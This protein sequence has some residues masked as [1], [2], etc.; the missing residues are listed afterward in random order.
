M[1]FQALL[2]VPLGLAAVLLFTFLKTSLLYQ[3]NIR[4][5][6]RERE[7]PTLPHIV[8]YLG[9]AVGFLTPVPGQ[10]FSRILS[11]FNK[12]HGGASIKLAGRNVRLIFSTVAVQAMLKVKPSVASSDTMIKDMICKGCKMSFEDWEKYTGAP[13]YGR[14]MEH[15]VSS[16]YLL[17]PAGADVLLRRFA[18]V[19]KNNMVNEAERMSSSPSESKKGE[20]ID[21]YRWLRGFMFN[22]SVRSFF[23]ERLFIE[24]PEVVKDFW[25]FEPSF[26]DLLFGVPRFVKPEPYIV[27]EKM[28]NG[29]T[30]WIEAVDR[31]M[32][33]KEPNPNSPDEDWEPLWGSR[34]IR[35]R[36]ALWRQL[37]MSAGGRASMELS[38]LFALNAN[39]LPSTGWMLMHILDP[40]RPDLFPRV[41]EEIQEAVDVAKANDNSE[42]DFDV[43]TLLTQPLLQSMFQEVLRLYVDVLITRGVHEDMKLPT[44]DRQNTLLIKK[45]SIIMAPSYVNHHDPTGFTGAPV[46]EYDPER[47][48]VPAGAV[49]SANDDGEENLFKEKESAH[50][51]ARSNKAY[52]FS[53]GRAGA[54]MI[55]FGGGRT[56]CP[57][58]VF[59]KREVFCSLALVLLN[60]DIVPVGGPTL[61]RSRATLR[62]T[63]VRGSLGTGEMS[64]FTSRREPVISDL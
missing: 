47:F 26:L 5:K 35:A 61:T 3:I 36:E 21:L 39:A 40:K 49:E 38:M 28:M 25:D 51:K 23:G 9:H 6:R 15:E 8:P 2:A 19:M 31:D 10:F 18:K 32:G 62:L 53:P 1:V 34:L 57:G 20:V 60:F 16:K 14:N 29:M 30:K 12:N 37:G 42:M 41:M 24:Y 17:R 59:A 56:M 55:P 45:G 63:A 13:K 50:G 27:Q 48:L 43:A 46:G 58:R 54:K 64:R 52:A 11:W 4:D 22:A 33:N 44:E 7:P